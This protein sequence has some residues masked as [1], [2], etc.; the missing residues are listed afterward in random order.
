MTRPSAFALRCLSQRAARCS[1]FSRCA[2][3]ACT[4]LVL[5]VSACMDPPTAPPAMRL[6]AEPEIVDGAMTTAPAD[7]L[8][9]RATWDGL[10]GHDADGAV[11]VEYRPDNIA[12]V[13]GVGAATLKP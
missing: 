12:I 6:A 13:Q 5:V 1:R 10:A 2:R 8:I 11:S 7:S 4:V 9:R 3:A